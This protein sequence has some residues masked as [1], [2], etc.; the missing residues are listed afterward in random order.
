VAQTRAE[1]EAGFRA[2]YPTMTEQV[3]GEDRLLTAPEYEARL[4]GWVDAELA[5]QQELDAEAARKETRRQVRLA[6]ARL[7]QIRDAASFTTAQR[8]AAIK[9]LARILDGLI[10]V[11]ID[12]ALI[13]GSD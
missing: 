13:E 5:R 4:A 7:Q 8:D 10:L 2:Q 12:L 6:R 9:D 1:I 3:N 11:V